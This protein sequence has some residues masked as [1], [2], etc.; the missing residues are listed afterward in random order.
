MTTLQP[1]LGLAEEQPF[2]WWGLAGYGSVP[3]Y[4]VMGPIVTLVIILLSLL[5]R[6]ALSAGDPIV[7]RDG[8]K[9]GFAGKLLESVRLCIEIIVEQGI[10]L[11]DSLMPHHHEGRKY[12]WLVV[13]IF[14]YIL[15]SNLFGLI[16]GFLPPSNSLNTNLAVA[17]CVFVGYNVAGVMAVGPG[18]LKHFWAPAGTPAAAVIIVGPL[19]LIIEIVGHLFRPVTL[20][21]RLFANMTGD[22]SAFDIF[23]GLVPLGVPIAFMLMGLLVALVQAYVFALLTAIYI[24]LAVS[25]DH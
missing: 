25:H 14:V 7:P 1:L 13:P 21:L 15:V 5:T 3:H 8:S 20:S 4:L 23:L 17:L 10:A 16:P 24:A 18:Y 2:T 12:L 19:L 6:A 9:L 22:H 11:V